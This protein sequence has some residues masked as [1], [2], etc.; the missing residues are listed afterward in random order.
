MKTSK[1]DDA[2]SQPG[3]V[4]SSDELG[5][6]SEALCMCKDRAASACPGEWEPG[7]DLGNNAAH[8]RAHVPTEEEKEALRRAFEQD[9]RANK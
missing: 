3:E 4:R 8:V 9:P 7:C 6:G 2:N 1:Q 5:A